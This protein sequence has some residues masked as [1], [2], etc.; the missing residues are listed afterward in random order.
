MHTVEIKGTKLTCSECPRYQERGIC[1]HTLAVA[2]QL[3][4]LQEYTQTYKVPLSGIVA[5]TIP[6]GAGKKENEKKN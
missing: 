4:K 1:A 5:S 2:R 3:G 6:S